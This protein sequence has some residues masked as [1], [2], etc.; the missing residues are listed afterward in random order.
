MRT[1]FVTSQGSA[2]ARLQRALAAG[3][4][5]LALAAATELPHVSLDDALVLLVVLPK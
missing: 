5:A 4:V 1:T 2:H 3:N